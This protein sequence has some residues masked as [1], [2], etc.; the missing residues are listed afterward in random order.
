[1]SCKKEESDFGILVYLWSSSS[2]V[3]SVSL[4]KRDCWWRV[5]LFFFIGVL[6]FVWKEVIDLNEKDCKG[7]TIMSFPL[8]LIRIENWSVP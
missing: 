3:I 5:L 2:L 7:L 4:S 8:S 6:N 1:M